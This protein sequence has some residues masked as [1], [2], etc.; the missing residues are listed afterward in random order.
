[1]ASNACRGV[2]HEEE[3]LTVR[4]VVGRRPSGWW[5]RWEVGVFAIVSGVLVEFGAL[6]AFVGDAV[7]AHAGTDEPPAGEQEGAARCGDV[8]LPHWTGENHRTVG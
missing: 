6:A 1:M 4:T 3:R 7:L 8:D 5:P 2:R